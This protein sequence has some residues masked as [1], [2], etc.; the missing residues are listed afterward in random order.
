RIAAAVQ[1]STIRPP[2]HRLTFRFTCRVRLIQYPRP[3]TWPN[4]PYGRKRVKRLFTLWTDECV[5]VW[6]SSTTRRSFLAWPRKLPRGW[7]M[8][9]SSY[10]CISRFSPEVAEPIAEVG[11]NARLDRTVSRLVLHLDVETDGVAHVCSTA[12]RLDSE[13]FSPPANKNFRGHGPRT[14][15]I[16]AKRT[17][18]DGSPK[19]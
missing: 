18:H 7:T 17:T 4:A 11:E 16:S 2:R 13:M 15:A 10:K 6:R 9:R 19:I 12:H 1:R 5:I 3:R 14:L 8:T